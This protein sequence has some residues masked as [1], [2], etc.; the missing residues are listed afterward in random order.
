MTSWLAGRFRS[1]RSGLSVAASSSGTPRSRRLDGIRGLSALG[2]LVYHCIFFTG[3]AG[4]LYLRSRTLGTSIAILGNFCVTIFFVLSGFLLF[5]E[6][7][8]RILFDEESDSTRHYAAR[9]FL[10]IYPAYWVALAGFVLLLGT[11]RLKGSI[12]GLVTLTERNL[13]PTEFRPGIAVTWTLLIEVAFYIFLP[14]A[15]AALVRI[16]RWKDVMTRVRIVIAGLVAMVAFSVLWV[17]TVDRFADG[18]VRLIENLPSYLGWFAAGMA[19]AVLHRCH[20]QGLPIAPRISRLA[21]HPWWCWTAALVLNLAVSRMKSPPPYAES[22]GE[23]QIRLAAMAVAAFLVLLPLVL[24]SQPSRIHL[25]VGSRVLAWVGVT[26]YGIYLWHTIVIGKLV[27][28]HTFGRSLAGS[29]MLFA[30]VLPISLLLGWISFR[31][32]ERPA[33]ALAPNRPSIQTS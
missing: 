33:M 15:A 28:M 20:Q 16:C 23:F 31:L 8:G 18:D 11:Y 29:L 6:F 7:L 5:R 4:R 12:F 30:L 17:F 9:R 26:S 25:V 22:A 2:V 24:P 21:H 27:T 19:L 1:V 13:N 3:F 14:I 10:R 32:I